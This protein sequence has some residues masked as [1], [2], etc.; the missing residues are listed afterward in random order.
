MVKNNDYRDLIVREFRRRQ[1][2]NPAYSLRAFS[3]DLELPPTRLSDILN[4]RSGL[5]KAYA[6][7]IIPNLK[8][9]R[10]EEELFLALVELEHGRSYTVKKVAKAKV[11]KLVDDPSL[12]MERS[13][14]LSKWWHY[15]LLSVVRY[16][17]R[18]SP[19]FYADILGLELLRVQ[20][21]L[22]LMIRMG[23]IAAKKEELILSPIAISLLASAKDPLPL[24]TKATVVDRLGLPFKM[25]RTLGTLDV[26][27]LAVF[28]GDSGLGFSRG[29][30]LKNMD[31][32]FIFN[33]EIVPIPSHSNS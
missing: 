15:A 5:S 11:Q 18:N 6:Q 31:E 9:T 16:F 22:E 17:K 28:F 4:R 13:V 20:D 27:L 32:R 2:E 24:Q 12:K 23:L 25:S 14:L 10:D 21:S 7:K 26:H 8:M 29:I 30:N 33:V 19:Q 3:K 1:E